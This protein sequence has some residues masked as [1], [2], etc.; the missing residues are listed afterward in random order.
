MNVLIIGE[1]EYEI[2]EIM[3]K[4]IKKTKNDP[5]FDM[6][7]HNPP[8]FRTQNQPAPETSDELLGMSLLLYTI[9]PQVIF[10][11]S[12]SMPMLPTIDK[13]R[14]HATFLFEI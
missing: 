14:I 1:V 12:R 7:F 4:D 8:I 6:R 2:H 9:V 10:V 3:R 13:H 5:K 11:V